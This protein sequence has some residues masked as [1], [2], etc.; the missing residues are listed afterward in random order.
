[1][2]T[3]TKVSR[4]ALVAGAALILTG[5]VST[6]KTSTDRSAI[7][8]QLLAE[9][10]S[11]TVAQWPDVSQHAGKSF[12]FDEA[13]IPVVDKEFV[14]GEI[15]LFLLRNGLVEAASADDAD[16]IVDARASAAAIDEWELIIGLSEQVVS[17]GP[18]GFTIPESALF[19]RGKHMGRNRMGV[20]ATSTE[21]GSLAFDLPMK[22]SQTDFISHTILFI[23]NWNWS[24]MAAPWG[25]RM[26]DEYKQK[27][28]EWKGAN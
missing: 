4:F 21:D 27:E 23:F 5:C 9:S 3:F 11:R 2:S 28:K 20:H 7:E 6:R 10:A 26:S 24:D 25:G 14:H 16:L 18:V 1:M 19:K 17:A 8:M 22:A 13:T 15:R 12:F